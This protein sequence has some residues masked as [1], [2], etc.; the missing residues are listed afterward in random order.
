MIVDAG[1]NV[2]C[3]PEY[4]VQFAHMGKEYYKGVLKVDNPTIGLVNIGEEEEKGNELTKTSHMLLKDDITLNFVGNIEPREVSLG[5]TQVL[6]CD[7]FV[8]NTLL[9]MYEGTALNLLK[10]IK[11]EILSLGIRGKFGALLLKPAFSVI[12]KKFDYKE[13]GGAPFLGVNGICIK[14]HGSSDGK[15]FRS[16]IGQ[17]KTF[18]DNKVLDKIKEELELRA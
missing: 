15:A 7:G 3:K 5:E 8:G 16:A 10:L 6:V 17:A 4:L 18:Y 14:A 2:D 9:K 11:E 13:Y 12:K 1:A